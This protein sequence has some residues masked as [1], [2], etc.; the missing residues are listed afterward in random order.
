V[1]GYLPFVAGDIDLGQKALQRAE[2]D[3]MQGDLKLA[4]PG[5]LKCI[6]QGLGAKIAVVRPVTALWRVGQGRVNWE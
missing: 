6:E 1:E 3:E 4:E 5:V 2:V